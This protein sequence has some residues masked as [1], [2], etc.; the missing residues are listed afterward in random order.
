MRCSQLPIASK[1]RG[2]WRLPSHGS[3]ASQLGTAFHEAARAKVMGQNVDYASIATRYAL[4]PEDVTSIRM[5]IAGI[6]LNI[7]KDAIVISDDVKL[8]MPDGKLE[9]TPDLAVYH[10]G[11]AT[12]VDW[13]S[14]WGNVDGPLANNQMIGYGILFLQFLEEKKLHVSDVDFVIA[15]PRLKIVKSARVPAG[16]VRARYEDIRRI[17]AESEDPKA[18]YTVGVWCASCYKTMACPAFSGEVIRFTTL[19]LPDS[20]KDMATILAKALP[21]AKAAATVIRKIETAAKAYV[22]ANGPLD[23]G[24]GK[25][26]GREVVSRKEVDAGKAYGVLAETLGDKAWEAYT[27]SASKIKEIAASIKRGLSGEVMT[28]LEEAGAI[29]ETLTTK[30]SIKGGKENDNGN[31]KKGK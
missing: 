16:E 6:A 9:G 5:G 19:A 26:Y 18:E 22:D 25:V 11:V 4:T 21:I 2:A 30:Y 8:A 29:A 10:N 28:R 20:P 1:C 15:L 12:I 14:G 24:D 23:L 31:D 7:P 3:Q 13:K 17:I 27:A